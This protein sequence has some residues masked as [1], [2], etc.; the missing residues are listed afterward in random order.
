MS[1]YKSFKNIGDDVG[2]FLLKSECK[3]SVWIESV[4][5]FIVHHVFFGWYI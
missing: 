3:Q 1:V 4:D 2:V 5:V